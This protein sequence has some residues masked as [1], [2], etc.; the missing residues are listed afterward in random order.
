MPIGL[1]LLASLFVDMCQDALR[2]RRTATKGFGFYPF[3]FVVVAETDMHKYQSLIRKESPWLDKLALNIEE[4]LFLEYSHLTWV[5]DLVPKA[6][7]CAL[8]E[9]EEMLPSW[10]VSVHSEC[11]QAAVQTM[12][13]FFV[14]LTESVEAHSKTPYAVRTLNLAIVE[15]HC[16]DIGWGFAAGRQRIVSVIGEA[17]LHPPEEVLTSDAASIFSSTSEDIEQLFPD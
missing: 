14:M 7:R 6:I 13:F 2:V 1:Q 17:V 16:G 11:Y 9:F 8:K 4:K 5:A 12:L 10:G 3:P 15:D